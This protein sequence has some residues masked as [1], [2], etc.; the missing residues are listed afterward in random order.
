MMTSS[1]TG[2]FRTETS[3]KCDLGTSGMTAVCFFNGRPRRSQVERCVYFGQKGWRNFAYVVNR[4][5][6]KCGIADRSTS[7]ITIPNSPQ[8]LQYPARCPQVSQYV[9]AF[10]CDLCAALPNDSGFGK[11]LFHAHTIASDAFSMLLYLAEIQEF[12]SLCFVV[13]ANGTYRNIIIY[14][15]MV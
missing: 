9:A 3:F 11:T 8:Y 7:W 2:K 6:P 5:Q 12:F 13:A 4:S 14:S 1:E 10:F 15:A